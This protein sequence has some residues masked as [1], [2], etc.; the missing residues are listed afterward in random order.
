[1]LHI[2]QIMRKLNITNYKVHIL[3]LILYLVS[4]LSVVTTSIF[5]ISLIK[6]QKVIIVLLKFLSHGS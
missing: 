1:M 4:I 3:F 5:T 6:K 2:S